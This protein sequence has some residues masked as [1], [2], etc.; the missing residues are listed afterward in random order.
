MSD[1]QIDAEVSAETAKLQNEMIRI[2][3]EISGVHRV[4]IDHLD[5]RLT[6]LEERMSLAERVLWVLASILTITTTYLIGQIAFA[7]WG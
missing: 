6:G 3:K 1:K 2:L 4:R 5:G 7:L